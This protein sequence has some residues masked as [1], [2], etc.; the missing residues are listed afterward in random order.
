MCD[1]SLQ[2][3]GAMLCAHLAIDGFQAGCVGG[4]SSGSAMPDSM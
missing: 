1:L 2:E 4:R 3:V